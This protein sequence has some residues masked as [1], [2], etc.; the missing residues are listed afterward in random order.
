MISMA[1]IRPYSVFEYSHRRRRQ[2]PCYDTNTLSIFF[3][4]YIAQ[5]KMVMFDLSLNTWTKAR[6]RESTPDFRV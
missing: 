5:K 2:E 1:S 6:F 4:V 3:K